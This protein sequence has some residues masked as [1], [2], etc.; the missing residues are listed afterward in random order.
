MDRQLALFRQADGRPAA[1]ADRCAHRNMPLSA[2]RVNGGCIECPYHG[3]KYDSAGRCVEAPSLKDVSKLARAKLVMS[4]PATERDGFIWVY[5]GDSDPIGAPFL[6]P[7]LGARG[8]TSFVMKTRFQGPAFI[9]LENFLDVPHTAYVHSGWFRTRGA[10]EITARVSQHSQGV[11]VEF[12]SEPQLKGLVARLLAPL[13]GNVVHT[14]RFIMPNISRVDYVYSPQRHFIITSQCTP[15]SDYET[16]VYTVMTFRFGPV[17]RL[18]RLFL[19][20]VSRTVI[21]QDVRTVAMQAEQVR[22]F[23]GPEFTFAETDLVGRH[24]LA[25]WRRAEQGGAEPVEELKRDVVI[26]Y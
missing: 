9:C 6:F 14:D 5:I 12:I 16:E 22:S 19:Q 3:W 26:R 10:T 8:W 13:R 25:L 17:G 4:F 11:D 2:G 7:F 20:P 24:I 15:V 18:V 21:K 23:G 1:L